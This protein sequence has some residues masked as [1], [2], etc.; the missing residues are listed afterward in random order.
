MR[1]LIVLLAISL[2]ALSGCVMPAFGGGVLQLKV[3]DAGNIDSLVLNI[4]QIEVH[5]ASNDTN[6]E[7]GWTTVN[8]A[9]SVDLIQVK[10]VNEFLGNTTLAAGKYTQIRLTISSATA[11]IDNQTY[12]VTIPSGK[13][14]FVHN[15]DIVENQTTTLILDF[16]ADQSLVETGNGKYILKPTVQVITE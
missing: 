10:G 8:G 13:F 12:S 9:Q 4:G 7:S 14:K 11:T 15:F 6:E 3:T 1:Y 2:I 5:V 16:D